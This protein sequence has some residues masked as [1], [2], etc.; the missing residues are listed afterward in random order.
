MQGK[1]DFYNRVYEIIDLIPKGRI[2]T[3]GAIAKALGSARSS[4][5]VGN[6]IIAAHLIH[7][8]LPIHRVVNRIG[9]LTGKN[10]YTSPSMQELLEKEG[11]TIKD[12]IVLDFH[13]VFWDPMKEI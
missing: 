2:T 11:I 9:L 5:M 8:E 3:Y 7:P 13:K 6:A 12:D 4:R 10:H 1:A